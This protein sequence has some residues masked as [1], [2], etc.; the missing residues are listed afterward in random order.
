MKRTVFTPAESK[1]LQ[2]LIDVAAMAAVKQAEAEAA[3][4]RATASHVDEAARSR[5]SR[6]GEVAEDAQRATCAAGLALGMALKAIRRRVKL[7]AKHGDVWPGKSKAKPKVNKRL[8]K[9]IAT[10]KAAR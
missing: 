4:D 10:K 5:A 6:A 9:K 2:E 8:P 3:Y 1:A 7:E